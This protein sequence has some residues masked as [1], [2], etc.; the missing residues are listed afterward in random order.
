[1]IER[2]TASLRKRFLHE[3]K[4]QQLLQEERVRK[5]TGPCDDAAKPLSGS[6]KNQNDDDGDEDIFGDIG[7][8][9]PDNDDDDAEER[10]KV[11]GIDRAADAP[12]SGRGGDDRGAASPHHNRSLF[13]GVLMSVVGTTAPAL[14]IASAV[15]AAGIR[16]GSGDLGDVQGA[17]PTRLTGL[18][19]EEGDSD[20][21]GYGAVG[22]ATW[23]ED[24]EK[25]KKEKRRKKK[26]DESDS[27]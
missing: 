11:E 27:D 24:D 10:G 18:A 4:P 7:D 21:G 19:K 8:Y 14:P 23:D 2:I 1:M 26:S 25:K 12:E 9:D 3:Q 5:A 6:H 20:D 22:F 15:A 13:G 17:H 16:N